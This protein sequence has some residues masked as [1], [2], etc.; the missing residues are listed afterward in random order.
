MYSR[1]YACM[2][3]RD[4]CSNM[5]FLHGWVHDIQVRECCPDT[6][7]IQATPTCYQPGVARQVIQHAGFLF[8]TAIITAPAMYSNEVDRWMDG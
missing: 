6:A 7:W 8:L 4:R 5:G 2:V 1:L 3:C